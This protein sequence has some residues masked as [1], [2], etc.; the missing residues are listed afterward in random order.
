MVTTV[1][2]FFLSCPLIAG[3]GG[4][5]KGL[6]DF[7]CLDILAQVLVRLVRDILS[8]YRVIY[9]DAG[10]ATCRPMNTSNVKYS[11]TLSLFI[12]TIYNIHKYLFIYLFVCFVGNFEITIKSVEQFIFN[13]F[14][15]IWRGVYHPC[16]Y[17]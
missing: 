11:F 4:P 8:W 17:P 14:P 16:V 9:R 12:V 13:I 6:F 7:E 2:F 3:G 1:Y 5:K 15:G 10:D